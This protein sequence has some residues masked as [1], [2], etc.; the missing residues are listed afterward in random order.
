MTNKPIKITE[1][2]LF[3]AIDAVRIELLEGML[4]EPPRGFFNVRQYAERCGLQRRSAQDILQNA[5]EDGK[6]T[7]VRVMDQ[8]RPTYY[9]G[10]RKAGSK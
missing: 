3:A 10:K 2:E 8:N 4:P 5:Y 9:Y 1:S 6:L 7:R